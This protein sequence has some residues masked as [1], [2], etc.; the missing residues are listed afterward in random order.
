M[1]G[2]TDSIEAESFAKK[3]TGGSAT[4]KSDKLRL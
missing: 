4:Q 2:G 3:E 1:Q